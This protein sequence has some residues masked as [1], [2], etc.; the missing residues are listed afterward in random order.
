MKQLTIPSYAKINL[1]LYVNN[2]R[3]DGFH[4]IETV[5]QSISLADSLVIRDS[6][7]M[8]VTCDN[9]DVPSGPDNLAYKAAVMVKKA[10]GVEKNVHIHI[11]KRIPMGAGL[12]GGS[13]N[14]AAAVRGLV[15]FWGIKEDKGKIDRILKR[16]GSDVP[17]CYRG[18]A[19][20]GRGRGERL[21]PLPPFPRRHVVLVNP[22][23][24][25]A[26]PWAYQSLKRSLTHGK[27]IANLTKRYAELL[28]K[29]LTLREFL[30][31]DFEGTVL[32]KHPEIK[33]IKAGLGRFAPEGV[34][35]SGSGSTVYALFGSPGA[36]APAAR[37]FRKQGLFACVSTTLD[38]SRSCL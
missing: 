25:V 37:H 33:R 17:F 19:C 1:A 32:K 21:K 8:K 29:R 30:H 5:F 23:I 10:F 4:D 14:A 24:H 11:L 34:L 28:K 6:P 27:K 31:N 13:S 3:P 35:M 18:G 7:A 36:A 12:A 2:R 38:G 26:T 20:L 9:P 22:G 15:R 16:L